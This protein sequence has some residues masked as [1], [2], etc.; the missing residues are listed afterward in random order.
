MTAANEI[1]K[2]EFEAQVWAGMSEAVFQG[3][4]LQTARLM[5]WGPVYHTRYSLGSR[6]GYPDLH[7][8]RGKRSVFME[9]K[10]MKGKVSPA[11]DEWILALMEA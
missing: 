6:A 2:A 1:T 9:L 4:V 8:L 7:L 10:T 3:Q 11:Q 5:G